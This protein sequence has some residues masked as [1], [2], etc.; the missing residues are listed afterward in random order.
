MKTFEN[1][2]L[3]ISIT[4]IIACIT[5]IIILNKRNNVTNE[6]LTT[7]IQRLVITAM[8]RGYAEG[9]VDTVN[10]DIRIKKVND[11]TYVW[12]KSPWD[13]GLKLI[14]DTLIIK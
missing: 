9:Q 3:I 13:S 8:E 6:Q 1:F 2:R 7:S 14:T 12:I 5:G 11:S 4:V 10:G